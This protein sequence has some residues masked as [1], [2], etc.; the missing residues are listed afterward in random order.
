MTST[1]QRQA[2]GRT[3]AILGVGALAFVLAQTSVIPALGEI[4]KDLHAS[5]S[6]ITWMVT[7]YLLVASVATPIFGRLGDMFGKERLLT[8]SLAAFAVGS[9]VCA[10]S[11]SLAPTIFGRGLQ[12]FGGGVF[13]LAFGI[14]RDE[15]EKDKIPTGMALLGAIAGVGS[16][17]GLPLG[18]V[19]VDGVG[20][21]WIFWLSA[22]M[23]VVAAITTHLFVPESPVRSPGRVD[24]T[25]AVM[26]GVGLTAVLI[27]IS[28]GAEW[29]WGSFDTIGLIVAGLAV[30]GL[31]GWFEKR[32][33]APLI[34]M[35]TFVRKPVLTTNVA[36]LLIG[37]GM[38]STFV[39]VPQLAQLPKGG[40]V[41]FGLSATEAGLLLV[42][43]G[44]LSMLIAPAVGR[45]G[46]RYGSKP[47][48]L[49]GCLIAAAALLGMGVAH[50]SVAL[51]VI[52]ACIVSGGIGIVFAS[53]P[54]L[55]VSVVSASETG[56]ATGVNTIMRNVGAAIGAQAAGTVIA[57]HVLG[58]G[59]PANSGFTLAFLIGAGGALVAA[60]CVLL[61]PARRPATEPRSGAAVEATA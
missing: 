22:I 43:G 21:H 3:L 59:L 1:D 44:L 34:N 30:L 15:F 23:G 53:V 18:G 28:R 52:W 6:G 12:G 57:S 42:P 58:N 40:D 61:I 16:S 24:V 32:S 37:V 41:G 7:A 45:A 54:N 14:V 8:L 11:T 29:G 9:I 50:G 38:I 25:G 60:A 17:I 51:V 49:V 36:T 47:P 20:Y 55:V 48:F 4:Q 31:F 2:P 10:V 56:E 46:T 39:L 13:P 5:A 19:L 26:L 27:A 35:T 33:S